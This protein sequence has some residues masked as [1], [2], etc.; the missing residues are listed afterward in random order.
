M[1]VADSLTEAEEI[2]GRLSPTERERLLNRLEREVG[3][4]KTDGLMGGEACIRRTRIPVWL[5]EQARRQGVSEA[6]L[7][8]NYPQLTAS[9]LIH[10]WAY[11]DA[12]HSEIDNAISQNEAD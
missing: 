3:I 10:A 1:N 11:A 12:H 8:R 6:D 2:I 4:E 7:L 9:D 5:L